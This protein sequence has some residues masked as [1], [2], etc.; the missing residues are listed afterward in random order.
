MNNKIKIFGLLVLSVFIGTCNAVYSEETGNV[1][2]MLSGEEQIFDDGVSI[3]I[4]ANKETLE[5]AQQAIDNKDF[6]TA[7]D[8]LSVYISSKSNKYEPYKLRGDAYYALRQYAL[9]EKDYQTAV[10]I[11]SSGDKLMTGTKY[12][13]AI[14][15]GADKNEQLQNVELGNLYARLMYAQKA[16]N[17]SAYASSYENAVKYN[18]HIYL[19]QPKKVE[20]TQINCP[21]KYGKPLN[22]TGIDEYLYGAID[23]IAK[24]NFN[25]ALYKIQNVTSEYPN[26]YLGHYITGVAL[27]GLE[28]YND[29]QHSFEKAISLNPYDFESYASLGQIYFDKAETSFSQSDAKKSIEYFSKALSL[30][31]NCYT[32]Y[33]Y[34]GLNNLQMGNIDLAISNFNSSLKLNPNDYNSKYYKSIAQYNKGLYQK[35]VEETSSLLLKHVSNYNSVLYLRALSYYK[36]GEKDKALEDLNKIQNNIEDIYNADIKV[37][38]EKDRILETYSYY[39]KS[40]ISHSKGEG[41][42]SDDEK[43]MKNPVIVQLV[44]AKKAIEPYEKV[45][46]GENIS[47]NDYKKFEDFYLTSLPKLLNSGITISSNDIEN[48]YD[49]IRTTFEDLGVTFQYINP[50]YKLATIKD[51]PYKKYSS[52]L[53]QEDLSILSGQVPQEVKQSVP[54]VL[55][56]ELKQTPDKSELISIGTASLAQML[57]SNELPTMVNAEKEA[58]KTIEQTSVKS[59]EFVPQNPDGEHIKAPSNIASGEPFVYIDKE[60]PLVEKDNSQKVKEIIEEEKIIQQEEKGNIKISAKETKETPNVEIKYDKPAEKH[61]NVNP[62]E[63]GV[64]TKEAPVVSPEDEVV[65]L[66]LDKDKVALRPKVDVSS[67]NEIK[68]QTEGSSVENKTEIISEDKTE[69]L[70]AD[71]NSLKEELANK[72]AEAKAKKEALKA[73]R[74]KAK[75]EAKAKKEE[76]KAKA[77]AEKQKLKEERIQ[78]KIQAKADKEAQ[79]IISEG[80]KEVENAQSEVS[81]EAAKKLEKEERAKIKAEAKAKAKQL[82]AERAQAKAEFKA[83]KT[84]QKAVENAKKDAVKEKFSLKNI[85]KKK[86]ENE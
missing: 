61:A 11:K 66:D 60:S 57:A 48:Q 20:I 21:Q 46:K 32:Y 8:L 74:A 56:P 31:S 13:S 76:L 38:T 33:F 2:L 15:L 43:A 28:K 77:R 82:K 80:K 45:L 83:Q 52:K 39:L 19:P 62:A 30:N 51:Y 22:P 55:K 65:V 85:F 41:S 4:K 24:D 37:V 49:Y 86:I 68:N 7:V 64:Q 17:N 5:K 23:E 25:E 26:Y 12:V 42:A 71:E 84:A 73:E 34:I 69:E 70:K 6:K 40:E 47:L 53:S 63:F 16:Q 14:V 81:L 36:M 75:A 1:N 78:A 18:S 35:V 59:Q 10:D 67:D 50:D 72:K 3:K 58:K 29:A 54:V 9:A 27:S 44:N 79:K